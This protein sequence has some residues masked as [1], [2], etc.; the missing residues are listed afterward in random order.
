MD[1]AGDSIQSRDK[2][3]CPNCR[4]LPGIYALDDGRMPGA[5]FDNKTNEE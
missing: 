1:L 3:Y 4:K 5:S 2:W